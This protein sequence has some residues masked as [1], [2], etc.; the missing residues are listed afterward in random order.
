MYLSS[1]YLSI[2]ISIL[3]VV[4]MSP[5]CVT[6]LIGK[7]SACT[8][9]KMTLVLVLPFFS[10]WSSLCC[11][12]VQ[13][14]STTHRLPAHMAKHCTPSP[15]QTHQAPVGQPL[16]GPSVDRLAFLLELY[17]EFLHLSLPEGMFPII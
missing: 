5:V 2:V 1:A 3:L 11:L 4:D 7:K 10:L 6:L 14:S 8:L 15:V 13:V 12:P 17:Q 16:S 9:R